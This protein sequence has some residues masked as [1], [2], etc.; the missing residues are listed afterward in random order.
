MEPMEDPPSGG[1][2]LP[3]AVRLFLTRF[4]PD[5][6]RIEAAIADNLRLRSFRPGQSIWSVG[7]PAY[8]ISIVAKGRLGIFVRDVLIA[9][10]VVGDSVGEQAFLGELGGSELPQRHQDVRAIE[11]SEVWS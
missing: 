5:P 10:C 6:R 1:S 4:C 11:R 3:A 2:N 9:Q 7:D 8:D